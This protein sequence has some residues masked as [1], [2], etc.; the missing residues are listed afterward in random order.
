MK[1]R[2]ELHY[3]QAFKNRFSGKVYYYY[4]RSGK[5]IPIKSKYGSAAFLNEI[6]EIEKAFE[7]KEDNIHGTLG[8]L[9]D[10][11]KCSPD[12]QSLKKATCVSYDRAFEVLKPFNQAK[13]KDFKRSSIIEMRDRVL[14]PKYQTWMANYAVSVLSIIFRYGHDHGFME[15]NPLKERV[16]KLRVKNK[17]PVNRPWT[18]NER[19]VVLENSPPHIRLPIAL[20]MCAGLRKA[21]VFSITTSAILNGYIAVKTSKRGVPIRLPIHPILASALADRPNVDCLQIAVRSD[22]KPWTPDGFDTAWHK[23][24]KKLEYDGKIDAGLTLHGLRHTLG[25]LLKE[26]GAS[27][28]EIA[29]VLGQSTISMAR[30]YS[31]EAR[32]SDKLE[33]VVMGLELVNKH[34][35]PRTS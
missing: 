10:A 24:K 12:Y 26:A 7:I 18:V 2:A 5:R 16:R 20:A 1:L 33:A 8:H 6:S 17:E 29:D 34:A 32:I 30:H 14:L 23:L 9:I 25:T 11:Y 13:L 4:R 31:K 27:D 15:N 35:N 22:G 3:I 19:L 21:D 28:G